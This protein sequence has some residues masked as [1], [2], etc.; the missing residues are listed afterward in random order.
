VNGPPSGDGSAVQPLPSNVVG[1]QQ[2]AT[3]EAQYMQQQSQIFVFST[4]LV[5]KSAEAVMQGQYPSI[6]A[7]HCAQPGTRKYLEVS[8]KLCS[9]GDLAIWAT[10]DELTDLFS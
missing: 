4:T 9:V 2:P 6:I 8:Y 7:Y 1:K 10:S 5:N 3:M